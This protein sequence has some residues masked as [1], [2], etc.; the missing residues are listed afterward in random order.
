LEEITKAGKRVGAFVESLDFRNRKPGRKQRTILGQRVTVAFDA[1]WSED[2]L[3]RYLDISDDP[4]VRSPAAVYL[5]RLSDD[6]LPESTPDPVAPQLP[7]ACQACLDDNPSAQHNE[8]LRFRIVDNECQ[9][10]PDCHPSAVAR[11]A[12][13]ADGGM[14][15][16]A[17]QRAQAR[18]AAGNWQGAGT[19]ERVAGWMALAQGLREDGQGAPP[20]STTDARV[21]QGLALAERF[22]RLEAQQ[23]RAIT[24]GRSRHQPYSGDAWTQAATAEMRA[25]HPHCGDAECDPETR[26]RWDVDADGQPCI[27]LCPNCHGALKF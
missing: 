22:R 10:C 16:R 17:M 5:H 9:A 2:G 11:Q 23:P 1:G 7:P 14:W 26:L 15:Q 12:D 8:R 4:D 3:R 13:T 6:E 21:A 25:K 20:R 19:D 27:A 24:S 18:D